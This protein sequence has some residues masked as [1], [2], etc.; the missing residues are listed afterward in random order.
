MWANPKHPHS[1]YRNDMRLV[2]R[3]IDTVISTPNFTYEGNL[4]RL[5]CV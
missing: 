1:A 4:L 5:F 2:M 3:T